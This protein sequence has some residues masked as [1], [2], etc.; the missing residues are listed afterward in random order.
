MNKKIIMV[1]FD[2]VIHKY[3]G[4]KGTNLDGPLDGA[5]EFI[6]DLV[7]EYE[8]IVHTTRN[9]W[10]V[11]MWLRKYDFPS[12]HVTKKK[13]PASIYIDDRA[14]QFKGDFKQ[15]EKDLKNFKV[16]WKK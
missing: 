8:V 9:Y 7:K 5:K 1:D 16:Y 2:G 12:L 3:E 13:I 4:W 15:L 6:E 14:V 11:R 10:K